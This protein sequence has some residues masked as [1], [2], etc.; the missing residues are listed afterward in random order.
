MIGKQ[1]L[2]ARSM[3]AV[4]E[5]TLRSRG[6]S[7]ATALRMGL[8]LGL[9]PLLGACEADNGLRPACPNVGILRDAGTLRSDQGVA[10]MSVL[11]AQC[12]YTDDSV[13]ITADLTLTGRTHDGV[14]ASAL[15]VTYFVALLDPDRKIITRQTFSTSIP[16]QN[17][18][19]TT[20]ET[21]QHAIPAPKTIDARWYEALTGFQLT[22]EQ[23]EANRRANEG[24]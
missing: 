14:T 5:A 19:G 3:A 2:P 9:A 22:P 16:L 12:S 6:L 23:V 8:A 21:L 17:G 10:I 24:R 15:P 11:T 4:S 7:R 1:T 18:K 13:N 20:R